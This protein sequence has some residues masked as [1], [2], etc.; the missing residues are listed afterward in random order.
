MTEHVVIDAAERF[1]KK[2]PLP[3]NGRP[4]SSTEEAQVLSALG[5]YQ[6]AALQPSMKT[7][8]FVSPTWQNEY[9]P[10]S[11]W[12]DV[13]TN[14]YKDDCERGKK[15]AALT[16]GAMLADNAADGRPLGVIFESMVENA[17]Q[18]RAKGG[19]G[20]RTLPGAVCGYLEALSEFIA[21]QCRHPRPTA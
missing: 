16:I 19:K 3:T 18:R 14:N 21:S 12:A 17:T 9:W 2:K 4:W 15:N 1:A 5:R 20:S 11:M 10:D 6:R 13:P 8:P 7:L